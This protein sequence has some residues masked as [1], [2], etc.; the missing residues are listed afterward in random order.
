MRSVTPISKQVTPT[1]AISI[2]Q[3][4]VV[5]SH[6]TPTSLRSRSDRTVAALKLS[7]D[8]FAV[9]LPAEANDALAA[10]SR[11]GS[12][13]TYL[14]SRAIPQEVEVDLG[15]AV[16]RRRLERRPAGLFA[17]DTQHQRLRT[18]QLAEGRVISDH[19]AGLEPQ[20][21]LPQPAAKL[22]HRPL[23]D[24][25]PLHD[26]GQRLSILE[27]FAVHAF[28]RSAK[29]VILDLAFRASIRSSAAADP[30]R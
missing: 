2:S 13:R 8:Y 14:V 29:L 28:Q 24:P 11:N 7:A 16:Q 27:D 15:N 21:L 25:Q 1:A 19:L 9:T 5:F 18:E 4:M 12:R 3:S 17:G 10:A 26:R 22:L 23:C 30:A 6:N 20:R